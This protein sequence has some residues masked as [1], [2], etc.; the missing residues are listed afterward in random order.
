MTHSSSCRALFKRALHFFSK[1]ALLSL[2]ILSTPVSAQQIT[3]EVITQNETTTRLRLTFDAPRIAGDDQRGHFASYRKANY[4]VNESGAFVPVIGLKV[5]LPALSATARIVSRKTDKLTIPNYKYLQNAKG[6]SFE[7]LREVSIDYKG[8][9]R[10]QPLFMLTV[11]PVQPLAG[12]DQ[13][14]W[15]REMVVELRY[16]RDKTRDF[17]PVS[18]HERK[19]KT[20]DVAGPVFGELNTTATQGARASRTLATYIST[21]AFKMKI[22]KTG[23]YKLTFQD[24]EDAEVPIAEFDPRK[25]AVYN[26][27]KEIPIYIKGAEDGRFDATDYIEFYAEKNEKTFLDQYED[28]YADPFT[29]LNVYWLVEKES[30]GLRMVDES[31]AVVNSNYVVPFKFKDTIHFEKDTHREIFGKDPEYM[32]DSADKYDH[33][34]WGNV[35]SS[36]ESRNFEFELPAPFETGSSVFVNAMF[37]GVSIYNPVTNPIQ[38][39][40]AAVWLNEQKVG[41]ITPEQRWRGQTMAK[42]NNYG[43]AGLAQSNLKNGTNVLRVDM[44]QAGL[45]DIILF[46]WFDITYDR[47]YR[48]HKD[49]IEFTLQSGLFDPDRVIQFQV[50]GFS[51][52]NIEIYKIGVSKILNAKIDYY[53]DNQRYTSYRVTFQ[54]KI[55]QPDQRYIAVEESAKLKPYAI[56]PYRSWKKDDDFANLLSP[57][58]IADLIII[59]ANI[60]DDE[61][62]PLVELKKELGYT[63]EVV[64]VEQ[65]YDVFNA[66]IKSPFAIKDFLK[67]AY[68]NWDQSIPLQYVILVGDAS[69]RTKDLGPN[70]SDLIPV[71]MFTTESFGAAPADIEYAFVSGDDFIPDIHIGRIPA[72]S[73]ADLKNYIDKIETYQHQATTGEWHN[74]S[75]FISGNDEARTDLEFLSGDPIFRAQNNRIANLKLPENV[76]VRKINVAK[77]DTI[78][79]FDPHLGGRQELLDYFDEG[80]TFINF[81]GHG[82]G[83]IWADKNILDLAGVDNL[84]NEDKYPFIASMT[85]FTGAFENQNREGLAEKLVFAEKKGAIA[86]LAS[87]SVGWK[88]NDFSV[89]WALHDYLWEDGVTFGQAVDQMKIDYYVNNVYYT[90][91][92]YTSTPSHGQLRES[93]IHQYNLLGDPTLTIKKPRKK[94]EIV[95]SDE[96]PEAGQTV[97]LTIKAPFSSAVGRIEVNDKNNFILDKQAL[98]FTDGTAE[99]EYTIPWGRQGERLVFK[100]YANSGTDEAAG[101]WSRFIQRPVLKNITIRPQS[102]KIREPIHFTLKVASDRQIDYMEL[103]NFRKATSSGNFGV[104][105]IME[106]ES[107]SIWKS[108]APYPG[109]NNAGLKYYEVLIRDNQGDVIRY[110]L[111]KITVV[112]NRPDLVLDGSSIKLG[113]DDR[114]SLIFDVTNDSNQDLNGVGVQVFDEAGIQTATPF[115]TGSVNIARNTT[116][117]VSADIS[118]TVYQ[119][120]QKFRVV[121][122]PQ[123]QFDERNEYN[124]I[125]EKNLQTDNIWLDYRLGTSNDGVVNDTLTLLPG[126]RLYAAPNALSASSVISIKQKDI[127]DFLMYNDQKDLKYVHTGDLSDSLFYDVKIRNSVSSVNKPVELITSINA[128][129]Y[130]EVE[131]EAISFFRFNPELGLWVK[132]P[133]SKNGNSI[134]GYVS[135]NGLYGVFSFKDAK[136]PQIEITANGRPLRNNMLVRSRPALAFL[137]QDENGVDLNGSLS[138]KLDNVPLDNADIVLP[139]T[140]ESANSIAVLLSPEFER[141]SHSLSVSI[142]DINGNVQEVERVFNVS[143]S[144]DLIVHGNYPNPF[145]ESTIISYTNSFTGPLSR[146]TVR[147]YTVSGHLIRSKQLHAPNNVESDDKLLDTGYHELEWDGSDD[148]GN[149]VA[150]GVYFAL[151]KAEFEDQF[152]GKKFNVTKKLKIARLQ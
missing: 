112:D 138:I 84:N 89:K 95:S 99:Y 47:L 54:D 75:L 67:Y 151:I 139:D 65:I 40:Q 2:W 142:S 32:S 30:A 131:L 23:I 14:E 5:N 150:N 121:I 69:Y 10:R 82:G 70:G 120:Q 140:I 29:D 9:Y 33:W 102:P 109:F 128:S 16:D 114:L 81:F 55:F 51:D 58:N 34:F 26:K 144:N 27:G 110:D 98:V 101:A 53:E 57:A 56:E 96:T 7:P 72:N 4:A 94:L 113:G 25:I 68:D 15:I 28:M 133:T 61:I 39:H 74:R 141:G 22:L 107:D 36:V 104:S 152:T 60:F 86:V 106:A 50:D 130:S 8:K 42:I 97:K 148:N 137:L 46:N 43:R 88:Y 103:R 3:T 118:S 132:L 77:N 105:V 135:G 37:R 145:A 90:E 73:A 79:G 127:T 78:E 21:K 66:G 134:T 12:G 147:I 35:I 24:L 83:A 87:S 64:D 122:D 85:C 1:A 149:D 116:Q 76:F 41:E 49:Y 111:Q 93:M 48:A 52:A 63:V 92:G 6:S 117:K 129:H 108:V 59:T 80:L 19:A 143:A 119:N 91:N 115:Y 71:P 18:S 62:E 45:T 124:N 125:V 136:A 126:W 13:V 44:E 20:F 100:V 31:G 11:A 17:E 146:L 123:N 38:G